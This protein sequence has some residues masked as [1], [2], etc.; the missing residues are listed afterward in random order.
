[1]GLHREVEGLEY[2]T[3]ILLVDQQRD[4]LVNTEDV[5]AFVLA[6]TDPDAFA[7]QFPDVHMLLAGDI[8]GDG[9]INTEDINPFISLLTGGGVGQTMAAFTA[10]PEP[11]SLT[12]CGLVVLF[13]SAGRRGGRTR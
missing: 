3:G 2:I 10:I 6:L 1:V 13:L 12:L 11:S 9:F 5:N 4:G 7:V 8:N